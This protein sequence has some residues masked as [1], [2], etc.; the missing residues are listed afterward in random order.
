MRDSEAHEF[1]DAHGVGRLG[2]IHQNEFG[3]PNIAAA[4]DST[5]R[6]TF[7]VGLNGA[8][9]LDVGAAAGAF[10]GL[11]VVQH[12]IVGIDLMLGLEIVGVGRRPMA[13]ERRTNLLIS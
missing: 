6:K 3:D 2:V 9:F 7:L 13:I 5:D 8:L 10:A 4:D 1:H 12:G 11:R